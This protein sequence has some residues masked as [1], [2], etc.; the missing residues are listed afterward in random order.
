MNQ[1][2]ALSLL[3]LLCFTLSGCISLPDVESG[4]PELPGTQDP[5]PDGG[6]TDGGVPDGGVPD[7]GPPDGGPDGGNELCGNGTIDADQGEVCDDWNTSSGDGCSADCR[8]NETCGNAIRDLGKN[9]A[10]D[11]GNTTTETS[12]PYG[13][14]SC[15]RCNS[16]CTQ[17]VTLA[18]YYCGD[19]ITN[20]PTEVCDDGNSTTETACPY[21]TG[22]CTRCNANCS[23]TLSLTGPYCGDNIQNGGEACDDG[24]TTTETTCSY[25]TATCSGCNASC[26]QTV[27]LSG[28]YCGDGTKNGPETCDDGNVN[29]CGTCSA[30]CSQMQVAKATGSIVAVGPTDLRDAE[31]LTLDDGLNPALTFEFDKNGQVA[32]SRVRIDIAN[33][34]DPNGEGVAGAIALAING[35]GASLRITAESSSDQVLLAHELDGSFGN[36]PISETVGNAGFGVFGM[37]GGSGRDCGQGTG[38][39]Q[40]ADCQPSL[41]CKPSRVCGVP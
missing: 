11:D 41:V 19:G 37:S 30:N 4:E 32:A 22:S 13:T 7:G 40:D 23:Q 14:A 6:M 38:C 2:R 28:P 10:C 24:N 21:G 12:C 18:G 25:G 5:A 31:T 34:S 3:M 33:L 16:N 17:E 29:A 1:N 35:V 26:T 9:E 8:S 36:R 27:S 39:T 15:I 20:A